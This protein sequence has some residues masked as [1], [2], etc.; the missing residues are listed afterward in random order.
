MDR[1][2]SLD[3]F[4]PA[5]GYTVANVKVLCWRCNMLKNNAKPEELEAVVAYMRRG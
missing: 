4:D 2:P 1:A 5:K 3:R